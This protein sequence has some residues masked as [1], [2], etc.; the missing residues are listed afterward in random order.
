MQPPVPPGAPAHVERT[1]HGPHGAPQVTFEAYTG[2]GSNY[3]LTD[4]QAVV[5]GEQFKRL[6]EIVAS[7]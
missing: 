3:Q 5:S 6:P 1:G 4:I 2:L 7:R